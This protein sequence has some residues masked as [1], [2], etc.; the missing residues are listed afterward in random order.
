MRKVL[1][2]SKLGTVVPIIHCASIHE[3][4]EA[5]PEIWNTYCQTHGLEVAQCKELLRQRFNILRAVARGM[6]TVTSFK[7]RQSDMTQMVVRPDMIFC[8][9]DDQTVLAFD[10]GGRLVTR[11]VGHHGGVW[12]FEVAG[13][14]V[15]TGSTDKT[16]RLW[17][18]AGG[19]ATRV[20]RGHRSTIRTV[21]CVDGHIITGSRDHTIVVWN[22]AGD[23]Q[24]VL[25][26]HM[27]SVRCMDASD[28]LLVSGS[29]DCTVKLWD[30]RRGRFLRDV[31]VHRKR[32]YAVRIFHDY[33][34]SG[35]LDSEVRVCS[36]DGLFSTGHTCHT[37]IV[38]WLD[39]QDCYLVSSGS[40]GAVVKYNYIERRVEYI[41]QEGSPIKSQ[42]IVDGLLV[43][44]TMT[45]VKAYSFATGSFLRKLVS[46]YM[47]NKVDI[48]DYK[49]VV[50]FFMDGD[51]QVSVF[52]YGHCK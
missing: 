22:S 35:G 7:T 43:V 36:V 29:Y 11:F 41:I 33:I 10:Y 34:A 40:D 44:G 21:K 3:C 14:V 24:H 20:L 9:S 30:Y 4:L 28:G 31:C 5:S 25:E 50:G 27:Q 19:S 37:S 38:A 16:A 13:D 45:E 46:A 26:G 42:R 48:I 2:W 49:I 18:I 8:S 1:H 47:I 51:Y 39:F 52:D 23:M 17:S 12:A 15:V 32:V 6:E